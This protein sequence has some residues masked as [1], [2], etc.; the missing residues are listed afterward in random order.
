MAS[1]STTSSNKHREHPQPPEAAA[2][3]FSESEPGFDIGRS[4]YR[5]AEG[6]ASLKVTVTLFG[7]SIFLILAG[8]LAQVEMD[9]YQVLE[10]YFH[11]WLAW[12]QVRHFFPPNFVSPE[13][14]ANIPG[15]WGFWF[16]GG[17]L[18]GT[19]LFVNLIA[20]HA[21][22]FKMQARGGRLWAG[23]GIIAL[24]V[25][26]TWLVIASGSNP[27]GFQTEPIVSWDV[28]WE[29]LKYGLGALWVG[30]AS[31]LLRIDSQRKTERWI[32]G[33]LTVLLGAGLLALFWKGDAAKLDDSA[34][35]IL[36][37]LIKGSA[38]AGVLL[39]GCVLVFKKRAGV[40]L[41]HAGIGLMMFSELF[42][43][44]NNREAQM[45]IFE[46]ETVNYV[47]DARH[48]ELAVVDRSPE[49]HDN[50]VVVPG[51]RLQQADDDED[52]AVIKHDDLP[53]DLRV[54]RFLKNSR[55]QKGAADNSEI[56]NLKGAAKQ[57][58]VVEVPPGTG[59]DAESKFDASSAYVELID[60]DSSQSLGT[61]LF[62]MLLREQEITVGKKTYHVELRA[63][64]IY[65][66]YSIH[67]IDVRADKY[68][69]S[70]VPKNYA[71]K[72]QLYDPSRNVKRTVT[73]R[74]NEPLRY[75]G[76]TFYQS[77]YAGPPDVPVEQSTLQVVTNRGWMI[78]YVACMIV[79]FGML[80]HFWGILLRFLN[81]RA[82][83]QI[84]T[85]LE[86]LQQPG[87]ATTA[88]A[89]S[90]QAGAS[91]S[92]AKPQ[93]GKGGAERSPSPDLP[94]TSFA[95]EPWWHPR[96]AAFWLPLLVCC[97]VAGWLVGKAFVPSPGEDEMHIY[98]FSKLPV[99]SRGRVKPL[100]SLARNNLRII[101]GR[102]TFKDTEGNKQPAI[103]W[104]IDSITRPEQAAKY[105]V[106]RIQ[107]LEVLDML[108]LA[109]KPG[110][111]YSLNQVLK[112][113]NRQTIDRHVATARENRQAERPLTYFQQKVLELSNKLGIYL[114]I[115]R[116][117]VI[118]PADVKNSHNELIRFLLKRDES[119][120]FQA[121][122]V[123][124]P[125]DDAT[126]WMKLSDSAGRLWIRR[127]AEENDLQTIEEVHEALVSARHDRNTQEMLANR[128]KFRIVRMVA[129]RHSDLS[130]L[131]QRQV[132]VGVWERIPDQQKEM[133]YRTLVL[134][135]LRGVMQGK[136]LSDA[137]SPYTVAL[138]DLLSAHRKGDVQAFNEQVADYK[139]VL[140]DSDVT[141]YD[142]AKL[143]F[144]A[145]FNNFG[146]YTTTLIIY[147]TAFVLAALAWLGW[148][149]PLNRTA[150]GLVVIAFFVHTA[151]LLAR[152][153]ISDRWG[154]MV[155][156]LYSSAIFIGWAACLLG[157]LLEGFYRL[158]IGNVIASVAGFGTLWI[159]YY[160]S[161]DGDTISVMQAVLDT[162]FWLA[163]HVTT[164]TLGYAATFAAGLLGVGY[165]LAGLFSP[166]LTSQ[167]GRVLYRMMYGILCFAIFFSFVGTVLG[168]LW[169]DDSWG[170]FW[171]W[172]PKENGALIIVLWNALVL[173][174]RWGG[175]VKERGLA[176]LAVGGNIVTAWSWFGVNLLSVGLHSYGFKEGTFF[177]LALFVLS[178]LAVIGLGCAPRELWWSFRRRDGQALSRAAS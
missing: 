53:F 26:T 59:T 44:L 5:V 16:P 161:F 72:F 27:D 6:L 110:Y 94:E 39:T 114:S 162:N 32:I 95:D 54:V 22:R 169:A 131:E 21:I 148:S 173:H 63:K 149:K 40:V 41:L 157:I 3:S 67:L 64:R 133:R 11:P 96:R 178:Q 36:W 151:A 61:Y 112:E 165:I 164:I 128:L 62:S 139:T 14:R 146:P 99:V 150:F 76:E 78:P 77:G 87:S 69:S 84:P 160:L 98:E 65:K 145:W 15:T 122:M 137:T 57:Y 90:A 116:M 176:V 106:F 1:H 171:G 4:L 24:G 71:S 142:A 174:A 79:A 30:M 80:A 152:M 25:L 168:G 2:P 49:E 66:P 111:R 20:A 9:I 135:G 156:N 144:E 103:V 175:L 167:V 12:I 18:I 50:V 119:V 85:H 93:R 81:R 47:Q 154:V 132:A 127:F 138:V 92:R 126:P 37:Q 155:T 121:L 107:S 118:P 58:S 113:D 166:G 86:A 140:A 60:K 163:T 101:A 70:N 83:G 82:A 19:A 102:E 153:Y 48:A 147:L 89:L 52:A 158:G 141:D 10:R 38:A 100:D 31:S 46:G 134:A 73:I 55:L 108:G 13:L 105:P 109:R 88:P 68:L 91:H 56:P 51:S 23:I 115:Q 172:D 7:L 8:T 17:A 97:L 159:A 177:W 129:Q 45:P 123:P 117:H 75:A 74:M 125:G 42:V 170:R 136:L 43:T 29:C 120:S 124:N 33:G 104:F 35:R 130:P 143:A 28:L 34:M